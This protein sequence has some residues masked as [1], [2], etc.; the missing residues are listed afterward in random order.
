M[1]VKEGILFSILTSVLSSKED[2][3]QHYHRSIKM[4]HHTQYYYLITYSFDFEVIYA[5]LHYVR[6]KM[7]IQKKSSRVDLEPG[8]WRLVAVPS[9][10]RCV[11]SFRE[12]NQAAVDEIICRP[13]SFN[14]MPSTSQIRMSSWSFLL[15]FFFGQSK[16]YVYCIAITRNNRW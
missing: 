12:V 11:D 14:M 2:S 15:S 13:L 3:V 9:A 7:N 6:W 10:Q 4:Q 1:D 16:I 8:E 5:S